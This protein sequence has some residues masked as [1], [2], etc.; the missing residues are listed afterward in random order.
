MKAVKKQLN[1]I[2]FMY[3]GLG[4]NEYRA[5]LCQILAEITPDDINGFLF[6]STGSEANEAVI[7]MAR[8]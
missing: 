5:R 2:P 1:S 6:T 3:S 8:N 4:I 7:R